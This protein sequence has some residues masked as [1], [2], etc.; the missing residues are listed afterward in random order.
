MFLN[1]EMSV[2]LFVSFTLPVFALGEVTSRVIY[3]LGFRL[4]Y[5]S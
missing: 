2:L 3:L 4:T 5:G 1:Q